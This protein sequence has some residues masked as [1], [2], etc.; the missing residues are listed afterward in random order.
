[1]AT[2]DLSFPSIPFE[3]AVAALKRRGI[4]LVPSD[5]WATVWQQTH[6]TM[7]TV[8]RSAGFDILGD[9]HSAAM[10]VLQE[11]RT[12]QEFYRDLKP[13]LQAKGWWG[14]TTTTDPENGEVREIQLGSLRRLRTIY[15]T[16]L[17]VSQAQGEWERIQ[18]H[19]DAFPYLRYV[20]ILDNRIRPQ[21][22]LWHDVV[23]PVDHPWWKT[24]FPPNG[25]KCRCW[26]VQLAEDDLERYG[27]AVTDIAPGDGF[28]QWRNPATGEIVD[29]PRGIDPGWAYN[30]GNTDMA[31]HAAKIA[32]DKLVTLPP[33]I[34]AEAVTALA[35]AFPQVEREL[36]TWIE[37]V[38][39]K[40]DAKDFRAT[41]ERRVVGAVGND[42]QGWLKEK[43][44]VAL[45]TAAITVSDKELMHFLRTAKEARGN[46]VPVEYLKRLPELLS[47]P[48]AIYWDKGKEGEKSGE[49][50]PSGLV[51]VWDAGERGAGKL[52]VRVNYATKIID[53]ETKK[54]NS[55][56]T[57]A[58]ISGCVDIDPSVNLTE[59]DGYFII[60]GK[61]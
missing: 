58:L 10:R 30:P 38:S 51:Y 35:F 8:A 34:G 36:A 5:H 17:R 27:L 16:N 4:N 23:L 54:R 56:N 57:N 21:H 9:I 32:M 19:K 61:P 53:S 44:T 45:E 2:P 33:S 60:K 11:G 41:G 26:I 24:H 22:R 1:M 47:T 31:A 39:A 15:D 59:G 42:V 12:F 3:E 49:R 13:V 29:V 20:G 55:I 40:V 50:R 6:H 18:K 46:S 7:F 25:W 52:V 48:D 43:F 14:K 37:G 28:T